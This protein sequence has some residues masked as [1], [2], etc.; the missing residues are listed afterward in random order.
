MSYIVHNS[1]R[2]LKLKNIKQTLF[3]NDF[4]KPKVDE[5]IKCAIKNTNIDCSGNNTTTENP[6]HIHLFS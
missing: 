1:H 4:L 5:Q 3:N 2:P 6:Q